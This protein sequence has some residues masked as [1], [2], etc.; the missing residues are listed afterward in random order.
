M[1]R[2]KNI[3]GAD[4][5][6]KGLKGL[7]L[8]MAEEIAAAINKGGQELRDRAKQLAP[9]RR[10]SGELRRSIEVRDLAFRRVAATKKYGVSKRVGVIVGVFPNENGGKAY[11]AR[12]VEFGTAPHAIGRGIHPGATARPF[13][14]PAYWSLRK[15]IRGRINRATRKAAKATFR[16]G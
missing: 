5:V 16:G 1:S 8:K 10:H 12:Y 3:T 2:F 6:Q 11:Y 14:F 13:L 4:V 15:R 9:A 7:P